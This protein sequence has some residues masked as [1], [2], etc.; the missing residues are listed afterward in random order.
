MHNR[1]PV[2]ARAFVL[3]WPAMT[4]IIIGAGVTGV[5]LARRL[6]AKKHNVVLIEQNQETARQAAN[7]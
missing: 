6:I 3:V 7:R 1:A 2:H 5:E 4:V